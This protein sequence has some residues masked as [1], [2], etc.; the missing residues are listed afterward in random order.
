[1]ARDQVIHRIQAERLIGDAPP[2]AVVVPQLEPRLIQAVGP[3]QPVIVPHREI[4]PVEPGRAGFQPPHADEVVA[5]GQ[6]GDVDAVEES[7]AMSSSTAG[8]EPRPP[9]QCGRC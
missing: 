9:S 3:R 5:A 4:G 1:M 2:L 8:R 7:R 6:R